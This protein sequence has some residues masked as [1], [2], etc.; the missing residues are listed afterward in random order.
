MNTPTPETAGIGHN[1]PNAYES[2]KDRVD[3]LIAAADVWNNLTELKDEDQ[4]TKAKDFIERVKAETKDLGDER[5]KLTKPLRDQ[6]TEIN[7][8]FNGLINAL[9]KIKGVIVPLQTK[10][11]QEE[12]RKAAEELKRQE[13]EARRKQQEA[14]EAARKAAESETGVSDA[15]AAEEAKKDADEA[16]KAA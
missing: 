2:A 13:D 8:Q 10:Y 6:T 5:L 4:A 15:L 12:A 3:Q 11:L 9:D 1:K 14:D 7:G 16:T